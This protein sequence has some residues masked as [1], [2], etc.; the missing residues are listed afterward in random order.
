MDGTGDDPRKK[1]SQEKIG[2]EEKSKKVRVNRSLQTGTLSE[3]ATRVGHVPQPAAS[4]PP[5][6]SPSINATSQEEPDSAWNK[7]AAQVWDLESALQYLVQVDKDSK[8]YLSTPTG[9]EDVVPWITLRA[10]HAGDASTIAQFYRATME[11]TSEESPPPES[12][13]VEVKPVA[14]VGTPNDSAGNAA[15]GS[16]A[17]EQDHKASMLEVWLADGLG[18]ESIPPTVHALLVHVHKPVK[19]GTVQESAAS[20]KSGKLET[21]LGGVAL[22]TLSL[23]SQNATRILRI[24]WMHIETSSLPDNCAEVLRERIWLRLSILAKMTACDLVLVDESQTK[25]QLHSTT[26]K[27]KD[28]DKADEKQG[29]IPSAE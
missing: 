26:P 19:R 27:S 3:S 4:A 24:E 6:P 13:E 7:P 5:F 8:E 1:R 22:M 25:P 2:A 18:N 20:N 17:E 28:A 10:G 16:G 11:A 29:P 15:P 21:D 9:D 12:A 14:T 23:G